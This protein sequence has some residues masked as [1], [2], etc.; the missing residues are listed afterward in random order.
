MRQNCELEESSQLQAKHLHSKEEC[1]HF[2][3]SPVNLGQSLSLME[4][5]IVHELSCK[6]K[7][8]VPGMD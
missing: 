8:T 6:R 4:G 3:V 7:W 2:Q 1:K 5:K